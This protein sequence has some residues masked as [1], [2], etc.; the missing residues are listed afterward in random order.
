LL[1]QGDW[2]VDV[3]ETRDAVA[4]LQSINWELLKQGRAPDGVFEL[5]G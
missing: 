2:G 1:Q 3:V 4:F 5:Q